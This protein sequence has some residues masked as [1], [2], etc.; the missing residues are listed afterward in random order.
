MAACSVPRCLSRP[1]P[2]V[3]LLSSGSGP[4]PP[5]PLKG[6]GANSANIPCCFFQLCPHLCKQLISSVVSCQDSDA[7][8]QTKL[9]LCRSAVPPPRNCQVQAVSLIHRRGNGGT[10]CPRL[11][12]RQNLNPVCQSREINSS[13]LPRL[14]ERKSDSS[15]V[16]LQVPSGLA[17]V[18]QSITYATVSKHLWSWT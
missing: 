7:H 8:K 1:S 17:P 9:R 18:M 15:P 11:G 13:S 3:P 10:I 16:H 4:L 14:L 2:A 12:R 6:Q 5:Q